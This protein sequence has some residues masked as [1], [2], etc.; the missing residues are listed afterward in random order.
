M[1]RGHS[2]GGTPGPIPNPEVKPSSADGTAR[3]TVW[4]SRSYVGSTGT[5]D[6]AA[7]KQSSG[8]RPRLPSDVY[9]DLKAATGGDVESVAADYA[10][11]G[12]ALEAGHTGR[13]ITL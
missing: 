9:R 4:E 8:D 1:F 5:V 13:A 7:G 2:G 11:A 6:M 10:A 3:A 12:V